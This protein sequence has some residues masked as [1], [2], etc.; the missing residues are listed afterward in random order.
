MSEPSLLPRIA[1]IGGTGK[2]G[3]GLAY[4]WAKAG[5]SVTIGSR[6]PEKA[7]QTAAELLGMLGGKASISGTSNVE[8][9]SQASVVVLTVPYEAHAETLKTIKEAVARKLLV[10]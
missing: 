4:R 10:D 1:V 8:A 2:E 6:S 7:A 3:K 9:A 5:Y